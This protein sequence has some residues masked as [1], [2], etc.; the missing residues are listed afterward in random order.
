MG[1]L[2]VES[3]QSRVP[4]VAACRIVLPWAHDHY[5]L[6]ANNGRMQFLLLQLAQPSIIKKITFGKFEKPHVCN[7]KEFKVFGGLQVR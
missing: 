1:H 3:C 2:C 6:V 5:L 4:F 7:M